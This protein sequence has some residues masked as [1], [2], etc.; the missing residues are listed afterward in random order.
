MDVVAQRLSAGI[1]KMCALA[2]SLAGTV[3]INYVSF[4]GLYFCIAIRYLF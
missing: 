3:A 2:V 4:S 1:E